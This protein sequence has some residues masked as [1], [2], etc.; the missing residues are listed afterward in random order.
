MGNFEGEME[1]LMGLPAVSCAKMIE[2]LEMS[3]GI[4]TQRGSKEACVRC[5]AQFGE[6][7]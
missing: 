4:W 3:F 1:R 5:D 2:A 7:H 6:C